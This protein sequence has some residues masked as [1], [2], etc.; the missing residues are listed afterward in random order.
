MKL[1]PGDGAL[2]L[3]TLKIFPLP[4]LPVCAADSGGAGGRRAAEAGGDSPRQSGSHTQQQPAP[5]PGELPDC[6]A[7][8]PSAGIPEKTA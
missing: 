5:G 6:R 7:V 1:C 4:A 8:R 3:L 2:L